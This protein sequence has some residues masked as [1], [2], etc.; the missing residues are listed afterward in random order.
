M[1]LIAIRDFKGEI[2]RL[3][4][5]LLPDGA[6][7]TAVNCD[8]AR[9][10]L[11]PLKDGQQQWTWTTN[12]T[13]GSL[14]TDDGTNWVVTTAA[15]VAFY[16]SPVIDEQYSRYY[17]LW[18]DGIARV[19]TLPTNAPSPTGQVPNTQYRL[20]VPA[21]TVAPTLTLTTLSS[22]P[23][24]TS[25]TW[26]F[27]YWYEANGTRYQ[28]TTISSPALVTANQQWTFTPVAIDVGTEESPK[29]PSSAALTVGAVLRDGS[30]SSA[31]E[32]FRLNTSTASIV[33]AR[34]SALPGG[35]E[36]AISKDSSNLVTI[37]VNWGVV[38]TRAYCY[39]VKNSWG[40]ESAPSP[41]ALISP[42]YIQQV[43]IAIPAVDFTNYRLQGAGATGYGIYRTFGSNSDYISIDFSGSSSPFVDSV[44]SPSSA[45]TTLR[46]TSAW[47]PPPTLL[48]TTVG[49][50]L[51][52]NGWFAAAKGNT[53]YMSEPYRPHA[54]PYS[55]TFPRKIRG[56]CVGSQGIVVTTAEATY[57]VY[58][59]HPASVTQQKLS[60]PVGGVSSKGMCNVEGGVAM[61]TN[62]GIMFVNG[63]KASLE[64][65][66]RLFTREEWRAR[67]E[68][69]LANMRLAYF[70][71]KLLGCLSVA[72]TD[73]YYG[74]V[75]RTDENKAAGN[76]SRSSLLVNAVAPFGLADRL[77]Y[78]IGRNVYSFG[79]GGSYVGATWVSKEH[80]LSKPE[81]MAVL[82]VRSSG[83]ATITL[84]CDGQPLLKNDG[85]AFSISVSGAGG[86][87]RLP[88]RGPGLRWQINVSS[89]DGVIYEM[90]LASSM[91]E[92]QSG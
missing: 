59:P 64:E 17:F 7:R 44:H 34:S 41:A 1:A 28:E 33:G 90:V 75:L 81:A 49:M 71:G 11:A 89:L 46:T 39:T 72:D 27:S 53:L 55:M 86:Y 4:A 18:S 79:Q 14:F 24:V 37:K 66:Q 32:I 20:G 82:Y 13:I 19:D 45:G 26:T 85:T 74:F 70:D 87:Y 60:V 12:S 2:P 31:K 22:I 6:A 63:T 84:T 61:I 78:T 21:P 30:G 62:D 48:D 73:G 8:F 15:D 3:P 68:N 91:K 38:D 69:V 23:G 35:V 5:H 54:W 92:L 40:E 58:G 76:F 65:G 47:K 83:T 29:T 10:Q 16:K 88:S 50:H 80:L 42:T 57:M 56:M 9:G 25:P 77:Y 67:Y 43:N 51:T 36:L 52:P